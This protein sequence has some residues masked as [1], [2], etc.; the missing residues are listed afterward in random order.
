MRVSLN[1]HVD[2]QPYIQNGFAGLGIF[3]THLEERTMG[4]LHTMLT[5]MEV[6]IMERIDITIAVRLNAIEQITVM[7]EKPIITIDYQ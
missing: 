4:K 6:R 7:V 5:N 3:L 1:K 2:S